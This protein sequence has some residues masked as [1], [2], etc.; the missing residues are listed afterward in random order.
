MIHTN[1]QRTPEA[2]GWLCVEGLQ[3]C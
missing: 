1:S 2:W 3:L